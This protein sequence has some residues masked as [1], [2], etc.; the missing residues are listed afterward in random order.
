MV[1]I[2][3]RTEFRKSLQVYAG[4]YTCVNPEGS[5]SQPMPEAVALV[6]AQV[7]A[8]HAAPLLEPCRP[9]AQPSARPCARPSVRLHFLRERT[10]HRSGHRLGGRRR[11]LEPL[12]RLDLDLVVAVNP[13]SRRDEMPDDDVLLQAQEVIA[14]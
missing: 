14:G 13:R 4:T 10:R 9:T 1:G 3:S 6:D 8:Q 11:R 5:S 12:G 2:R 7:G